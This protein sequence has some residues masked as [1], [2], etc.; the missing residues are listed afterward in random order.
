MKKL[1]SGG[2]TV[3][4]IVGAVFVVAAVL[5]TTGFVIG[6][7]VSGNTALLWG[8]LG[9]AVFLLIGALLLVMG[10]RSGAVLDERGLA[11][12][13][14]LGA[15]RFIPWD[16]V[17]QVQVP[18]DDHPGTCVQLVLRDG[19]VEHVKA[20]SKPQNSETH[21]RWASRGYLER[22]QLVSQAHQQWAAGLTTRD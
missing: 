20:I 11:W 10:F 19:S 17:Q 18:G 15:R 6:T 7:V 14:A 4:F 3:M 12:T 8:L 5:A 13:P 1:R 21:R 16:Q 2:S 22:G 9:A